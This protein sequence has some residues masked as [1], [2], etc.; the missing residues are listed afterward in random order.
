MA[1]SVAMS[2]PALTILPV[3]IALVLVL[4]LEWTEDYLGVIGIMLP[5]LD[6]ISY[7]LS[8]KF[9]S[10]TLLSSLF[11]SRKKG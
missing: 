8:R 9:T 1:L 2:S 3:F 6:V 4:V 11:H 7:V 5:L 10:S